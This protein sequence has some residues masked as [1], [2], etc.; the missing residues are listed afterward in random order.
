MTGNCFFSIVSF[1]L[2]TVDICFQVKSYLLNFLHPAHCTLLLLLKVEKYCPD[3]D[4]VA[5]TEMDVFIIS[6][7]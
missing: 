5:V 1:E 3:I 6:Y 2:Q 7:L 4:S